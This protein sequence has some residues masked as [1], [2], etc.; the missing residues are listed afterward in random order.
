MYRCLSWLPAIAIALAACGS[1]YQRPRSVEYVTQTILAPSCG[2][3][4]C[5]SQFR[6]ASGFA[7]DTVENAQ[8]SLT[9]GLIGS[10][11]LN[12][13]NEPVGDPEATLLVNVLTRTLDRMPYDQPLPDAE[14]ELIRDWIEY[15]APGAQCDPAAGARICASGKVVECLGSFD[16]GGV[17]DDCV[18]R[19]LDCLAGACR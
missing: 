7:F 13:L 17:L 3:A 19:G 2:N 15:G 6:N 4:Q 16:Y 9:S 10:I 1:E 14:I 12:S 18:A 5:H 8:K 11:S